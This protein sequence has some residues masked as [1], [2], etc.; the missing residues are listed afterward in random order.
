MLRKPTPPEQIR[1]YRNI[2]F[3]L[4][5]KTDPAVFAVH[6][7]RRNVELAGFDRFT[8][9]QYIHERQQYPK[10]NKSAWRQPGQHEIPARYQ[11][12]VKYTT[13]TQKFTDTT[14][15]RQRQRKAQ[16]HAKSVKK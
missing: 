2:L 13:G 10:Q 3:F 4:V 12:Y 5:Y 1:Y 6:A 11:Y 9:I 14:K 15:N 7:L 8:L 16:P